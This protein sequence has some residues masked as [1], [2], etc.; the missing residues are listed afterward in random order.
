MYGT[1]PLTTSD[2]PSNSM[3][4]TKPFTTSDTPSDSMYGT[5]P[6]TTSDAPSDSMEIHYPASVTL[7]S[8][9]S[10]LL[11]SLVSDRPQVDIVTLASL[12]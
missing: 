7:T 8:H 6:F 4:G 1:K 11:H 10:T 12:R 5:K 3:Y 2:A 9:R